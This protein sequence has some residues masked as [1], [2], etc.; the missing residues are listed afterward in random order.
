MTSASRDSSRSGKRGGGGKRGTYKRFI[1]DR[2][3]LALS[4]ELDDFLTMPYSPRED[5]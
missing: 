3:K 4:L 1:L 2:I 5:P